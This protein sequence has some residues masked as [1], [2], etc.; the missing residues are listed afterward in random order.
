MTG[1]VETLIDNCIL[2]ITANREH[3]KE[4]VE[5]SAALATELC[6]VLGYKKSADIAKQSMTT[7]VSVRKI[8]LDEKLMTEAQLDLCLNLK[9]MTKPGHMA[10]FVKVD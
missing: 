8:V 2:G 3:C 10:E 7:G 9:D 5:S 1:A 4:L 6:P